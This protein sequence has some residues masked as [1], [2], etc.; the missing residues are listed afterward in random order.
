MCGYGLEFNVVSDIDLHISTNQIHLMHSKLTSSLK[1]LKLYTEHN[2]DSQE[3]NSSVQDSGIGSEGSAATVQMSAVK[4][5]VKGQ[6]GISSK[7]TLTPVDLLLTAGRISCTLYTHKK[8][9]TETKLEEKEEK[10]HVNKKK[11]KHTKQDLE[12]RVD[13]S[14]EDNIDGTVQYEGIQFEDPYLMN[15][16]QLNSSA[17]TK[18]IPAGSTCIEPFLFLYITQPHT[19]LSCQLDHQK[20]ETSCYDILVKGA[21]ENNLIPGK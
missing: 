3:E 8:I 11:K 6:G 20:F 9:E 18:V 15:M 2:D 10:L 12:W 5:D 13:R 21:A 7:K 19:V 14:S 16:Y 4:Q 17:E 1:A